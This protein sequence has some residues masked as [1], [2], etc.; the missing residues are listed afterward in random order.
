[1]ARASYASIL[2]ITAGSTAEL[3]STDSL[4]VGVGTLVMLRVIVPPGP[5]GE[6]TVYLKHNDRQLIPAPGGVYDNLDDDIIE[7]P[8]DFP[9]T[10]NEQVLTLCGYAPVANF[11]H[12]VRWEVIVDVTETEEASLTPSII[13]DR[14]R[15]FLG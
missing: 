13:I 2:T 14:L 15:G 8:C 3:P 6:I 9:I 4:L 10:P 12:D 5:L 11:D 1:M 7:T